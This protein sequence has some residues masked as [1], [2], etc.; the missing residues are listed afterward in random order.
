MATSFVNRKSFTLALLAFLFTGMV[1]GGVENE[2]N[3]KDDQGRRQGYWQIKGYMANDA[4]YTADAVV[5]EGTFID[6]RKEGLWKKYYPTGQLKSEITFVND[7]PN[8]F[9]AV[10][11]SNG[12]LEEKGTWARKK[13][14]GEFRR[15]HSNGEPQQE[16]FFNDKGIRNGT[17]R[18]YH[19]NGQLALEVSVIDGKETGTM[20]RW[21]EKG[22]LVEEKKMTDGKLIEGSIKRYDNPVS[23]EEAVIEIPE[24]AKTSEVTKDKTNVAH[25]FNGNGQNVL[26]NGNQQVTQVGEFKNGRLWDG[27]WNRYNSEGLLIRIEIYKSGRYV[28][29]GV[30]EEEQ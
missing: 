21:D 29:D 8:G 30:I 17:Q 10:Y 24:G 15:F 5:E 28:G 6:D 13:N 26:Y 19:D 4:K 14:T 25:R 2:F 7:R 22:K 12:N 1:F 20:K 18:Y 11:Y 27:K 23:K 9:Y 16:F 3:K